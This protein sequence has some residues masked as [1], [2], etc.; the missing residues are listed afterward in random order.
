[1]TAPHTHVHEDSRRLALALA[2]V[3]ATAAL[4]LWGAFVTGSLALLADFGHVLS[5]FGALALALA[6]VRVGSRPH[7]LQ[8]TFGFHRAEVLAAAVNG[9]GLL[10]IAL[11]IT[12]QAAIRLRS[13]PPEVHAA[14]LISVA[15]AG[16]VANGGAAVLL[17]RG[18]SMNMRAARLHV[19]FD[20]G[21][22]LMAIL[23]GVVIAQTGWTRVDALLSL[24][25]VVL[26]V[27]AALRLLRSAV[28]VLMDAV[29]PGID[30]TAVESALRALDEIRAVHD[31]HCWAI[32]GDVIAF[33][34]HI[35]V[36]P[37]HD[38]Q[39]AI[40]HATQ[41]LHERFGI[42][43]VTLQPELPTLYQPEAAA[44]AR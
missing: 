36:R 40:A 21:G 14:G 20:L 32:H 11:F 5:D 39:H 27:I 42:D 35:E 8:W 15:T 19:L 4:E 25:I 43:H 22:S 12:V 9:L 23:A 31:V 7:T 34:A 28:A 18:E 3:G 6:A 2:L 38:P 16:L 24:A 1:V 29:P 33:A 37:G 41:V 44:G 26:L 30:L 10:A 13:A 17:A